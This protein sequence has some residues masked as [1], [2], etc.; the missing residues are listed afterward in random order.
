MLFGLV[1]HFVD[2]IAK[3]CGSYRHGLIC[4]RL[5]LHFQAIML[6]QHHHSIGI[7][8]VTFL[9]NV[10]IALLL[11]DVDLRPRHRMP[12]PLVEYHDFAFI[13]Q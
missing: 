2:I 9:P 10:G 6:F 1:R 3:P 8:R 12:A 4:I 5:C 13:S 11:I 7:G